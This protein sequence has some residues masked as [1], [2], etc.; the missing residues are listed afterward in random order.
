MVTIGN[1]IA[2][3]FGFVILGSVAT[4]A[5]ILVIFLK[6]EFLDKQRK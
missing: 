5:V 4:A 2:G 6:I 1:I 3:I